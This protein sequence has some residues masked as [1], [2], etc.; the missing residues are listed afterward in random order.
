[1]IPFAKVRLLLISS[2]LLRRN[3]ITLSVLF[4]D[5]SWGVAPG[6][7]ARTA[8]DTGSRRSTARKGRIV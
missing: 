8:D 2:V 3:A 6:G 5:E 1:M 7:S 4:F